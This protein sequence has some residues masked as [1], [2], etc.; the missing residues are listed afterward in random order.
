MRFGWDLRARAFPDSV[1]GVQING[2]VVVLATGFKKPEISFFQDELFPEGYE[3][4]LSVSCV[5]L[6]ADSPPL[7]SPPASE[8]VSAELLDGRLVGST[9]KL[10]VSER[11]WDCVR[12]VYHSVCIHILT[13]IWFV[14]I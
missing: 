8:F 14:R 11:Y 2:D 12:C 9:D 7:P 3:V 1:F 10:G 4:R 5:Q 6:F 13:A